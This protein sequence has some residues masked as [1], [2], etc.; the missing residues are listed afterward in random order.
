MLMIGPPGTGKLKG[1]ELASTNRETS[2]RA[3]ARVQSRGM[4]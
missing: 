4:D 1:L 3:V 2:Q